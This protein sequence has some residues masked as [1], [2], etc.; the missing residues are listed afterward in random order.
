MWT[1][2][3]DCSR[4]R[5]RTRGG[6]F[7]DEERPWWE[8]F[9]NAEGKSIEHDRPQTNNQQYGLRSEGSDL[10]SLFVCQRNARGDSQNHLMSGR[11]GSG[12]SPLEKLN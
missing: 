11:K 12:L 2:G 6:G 1:S 3:E 4:G 7:R 10:E 8:G 5:D 9:I